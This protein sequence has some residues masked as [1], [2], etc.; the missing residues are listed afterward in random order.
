M[1]A[2]E[3][4]FDFFEDHTRAADHVRHF[5]PVGFG[6]LCFAMAAL[7]VFLAQAVSGKLSP[8]SFSWVSLGLMVVWQLALGFLF[9][10]VLHLVMEFEGIQGSAA[11]LFVLMG[12][13]SL[14]WSAAVPVALVLRLAAP[15][16]PWIW[17]VGFLAVGLFSLGYKARSIQDN[18]QVS[19]ARA[20]GTLFA[21]YIAAVFAGL[22]LFAIAVVG[23][24][25]QFI[26]MMK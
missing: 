22:L 1:S 3:L 25:N 10:A 11:S 4:V 9:T 24:F 20:W 16:S 23:T 18:Y 14:V 19:A 8:F 17:T 5:K 2:I 26:Q 21:P 12:L 15:K 6:I 13:T 7:S